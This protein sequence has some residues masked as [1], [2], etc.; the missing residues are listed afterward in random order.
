MTVCDVGLS[1]GLHTGKDWWQDGVTPLRHL[2]QNSFRL[3]LLRKCCA[4]PS[5]N[6]P[7]VDMDRCYAFCKHASSSFKQDCVTSIYIFDQNEA[8][9]LHPR[10]VHVRLAYRRPLVATFEM[11]VSQ[12]QSHVT[13]E[14]W[15]EVFLPPTQVGIP[16]FAV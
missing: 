13:R 3:Q 12:P 4:V 9:R 1:W 8:F 7:L 10:A 14:F 16:R 15:S 6:G 2:A 5:F 11:R